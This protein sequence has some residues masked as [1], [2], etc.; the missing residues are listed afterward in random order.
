MDIPNQ[1]E[2]SI[3]I[4]NHLEH[5]IKEEGLKAQNVFTGR[6]GCSNGPLGLRQTP[7]RRRGQGL[8]S[9]VLSVDLGKV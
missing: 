5:V 9:R 1:L 8:Q 2:A 6:R 4:L 3:I 7:E